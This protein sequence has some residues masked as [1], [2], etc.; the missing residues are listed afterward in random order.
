MASRR[1]TSTKRSGK[2][3]G[4]KT[5]AELTRLLEKARA[6]VDQL[7]KGHRAGSLTGKNLQARLKE[8]D[9][10]LKA[11]AP[12]EWPWWGRKPSALRKSRNG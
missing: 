5:K 11:M 7:L 3:S 6:Q 9:K 12:F 1:T 4:F 8:A 2:H 10:H